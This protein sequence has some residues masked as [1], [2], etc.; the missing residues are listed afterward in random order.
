[1]GFYDDMPGR[2]EPEDGQSEALTLPTADDLDYHF[3]NASSPFVLKHSELVSDPRS[4]LRRQLSTQAG[5]SNEMRLSSDDASSAASDASP[6]TLQGDDMSQSQ[7]DENDA[8]NYEATSSRRQNL[9]KEGQELLNMISKMCDTLPEIEKS[10]E[11]LELGSHTVEHERTAN[12]RLCFKIDHMILGANIVNQRLD[13]L[14][15]AAAELDMDVD[16]VNDRAMELNR[17]I[18]N[19]DLDAWKRKLKTHKRNSRRDLPRDYVL[20]PSDY[21]S[22]PLPSPQEPLRGCFGLFPYTPDRDSMEDRSRVSYTARAS[23]LS[24]SRPAFPYDPILPAAHMQD[25]PQQHAGWNGPSAYHDYDHSTSRYQPLISDP[26]QSYL[27][28]ISAPQS[29]PQ[30]SP[31]ARRRKPRRSRS[32]SPLASSCYQSQQH[33]YNSRK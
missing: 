20:V 16:M 8:D 30:L 31:Q 12:R 10:Y 17:E 19:M 4:M 18:C 33:C 27:D 21:A 5:L 13:A 14:N 6:V 23:S 29:S 2:S 11:A 28:S 1:M 25:P 32:R 9:Y 3:W 7:I 22:V 15:S 26:V 24:Y